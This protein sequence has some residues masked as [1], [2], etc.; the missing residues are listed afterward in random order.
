MAGEPES[1][2]RNPY[3]HHHECLLPASIVQI[4]AGEWSKAIL[5]FESVSLGCSKRDGKTELD[6]EVKFSATIR[7]LIV[8]QCY[9]M[10]EPG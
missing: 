7:N 4:T 1:T 8:T 2:Q 3:L 5:L 9:T 6:L 10:R